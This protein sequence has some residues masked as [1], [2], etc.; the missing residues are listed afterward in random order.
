MTPL[1]DILRAQIARFGP[2]SVAEYMTLCLLHPEHGYYTTR[3][4]LGRAGDFVTAPEISQMFGELIGLWLAQVWLDQGRPAPFLL[5]ELG[6]G[7]GT[8]MAD[9]LRA[10]GRVPGFLEAADLHL[11]EA[12]PALR[13]VQ[14]QTLAGFAVA[15]QDQVTDLPEAPL[16][17]VA[18][19]FFDALPIRQFLRDDCGWRER[20]VGL[21]DGRL[22]FGLG[23]LLPVAA[24]EDAGTGA[25]PG[26]LIEVSSPVQDIAGDLAR[27]IAGRGG[28]A[29]IIDYGT[30]GEPGDTFQAIRGHRKVD[31]MSVPG[32]TDLTAHVDFAALRRAT[33]GVARVSGPMAQG[34][35]LGHLGIAARA[36]A[37]ALHL[38]GPALDAHVAAFHRLTDPGEMGTL[39]KVMALSPESAPSLPGL[40]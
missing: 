4:P 32:R 35:F 40:D 31:P 36:E 6:P 23:P 38:Q 19:E 21:A 17:L 28:V 2:M 12:S 11:V 22:S 37:L 3:D 1:E 16:F 7:R 5:A 14:A 27:R 39:F 20:L 34:A 15:F 30:E 10:A 18:N 29:L 8:L 26:T 24:L 25:A 33:Q 9:L 13:K